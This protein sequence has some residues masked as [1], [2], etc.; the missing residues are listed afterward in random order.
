M[1][2]LF[3]TECP[4]DAMQG[5]ASFIP[6]SEKASYINKLLKVGFARLDFGS[7]VSPKVMPQMADTA[8]VLNQLNYGSTPLLAI[9]ANEQGAM[10]ALDFPQIDFLGFPLSISETF[11]QR[12]TRASIQEAWQRILRIQELIL[13]KNK[14]LL[15]YLSMG[16]GNPYNEFYSPDL[17]FDWCE[18]LRNAGIFNVSLSDTI[19]V[20]TPALIE[21][22]GTKILPEFTDLEINLHLHSNPLMAQIKIETALNAGFTHF[23][24]AF[25]GFGGCPMAKDDLTGNLDTVLM[26]KVASQMGFS[27]SFDEHAFLEAKSFATFF[28]Q[29][30]GH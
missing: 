23:D 22:I 1:K 20:A 3:L 30:F 15:V 13:S 8:Q 16:F 26:D 2:K 29:K 12:N 6:T 9:I 11:Q 24:T 14:K 21:S 18:K 17:L 10:N 25:L 4:R 5:I 19:G 28:F 7:F 27:A